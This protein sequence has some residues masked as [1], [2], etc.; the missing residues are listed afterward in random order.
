P[1]IQSK[2]DSKNIPILL[3]SQ[4]TFATSKLIDDM[5]VLFT[6]DEVKKIDLL[7]GLVIS[8]LNLDVFLK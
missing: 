4:D 5:E 6:K 2:A 7:K 3:V 8:N 1:I